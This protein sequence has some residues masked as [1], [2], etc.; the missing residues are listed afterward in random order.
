[1][2]NKSK[3]SSKSRKELGGNLF[4]S[5]DELSLK[6][7]SLFKLDVNY[8]HLKQ[9]LEGVQG[10]LDNHTSEI[11]AIKKLV[12]PS[13]IILLVILTSNLDLRVILTPW[14]YSRI[15]RQGH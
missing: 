6:G 14:R 12:G 5:L 11:E 2:D 7:V 3:G 8:D 9:F 10:D 4:N 15:F 13:E 1:M